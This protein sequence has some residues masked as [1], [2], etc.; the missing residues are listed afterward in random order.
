MKELTA[1]RLVLK[2]MCSEYLYSVDEYASDKETCKYMMFLPNESLEET[3]GFLRDAENEMSK[4]AP[5]YYEMAVFLGNALIGA[6]SLYL[7]ETGTEGELGWVINRKYHGRGFASEAAEVL[8]EFAVKELG[9]KHFTAHCDT[10]NIP[11]RRVMEKLGMK[12][13][14]EY[15]GRKNRLSDEERREYLYELFL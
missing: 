8:L 6:V 4:D 13:S 9:I 7:N 10:E 14:G 2:P 12:L 15:G 3:A 1:A 5:S 11:S